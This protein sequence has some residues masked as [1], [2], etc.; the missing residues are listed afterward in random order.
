[1]S[2]STS[3]L[4]AAGVGVAIAAPVGP[5]SLLCMRRTLAGGWRD[6]LAVGGG[7]A[8]GDATYALV[9]ALGLSGVSGFALSYEKPLHAAAG[10]FLVY[11]GLTTFRT[12]HAGDDA[13]EVG[14]ARGGMR[15]LWTSTL[16]TLANPPTIVMFAAVFTALAPT[17]GFEWTGALATVAGVFTGS[18][19]WWC[20][21]VTVAGAFR[22]AIGRKLRIWI[23]RVAGAAL[24]AF[25][26]V[27]LRRAM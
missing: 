10:L 19:L 15:I 14:A 4:Q 17:G 3:F 16:L 21:L 22:H 6:G 5:M 13:R 20:G 27:E 25:G 24:A 11:L 2:I 26:I 1:M 23:D 12:H 8:L 9:A 7:V 18:F